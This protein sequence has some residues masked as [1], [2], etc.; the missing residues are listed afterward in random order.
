MSVKFSQ[1]FPARLFWKP[2]RDQPE[3]F[4]QQTSFMRSEAEGIVW[5]MGGNGAGTT[6][7]ALA[8]IARFVMTTPPPRPDCPI[9]IIANTLEQACNAC[10]KEKLFGHGHIMACDVDWPRIAWYK[11]NQNWPFSVPLKSWG[12]PG[13]NWKL[14]FKSYEQGREVMQAES[15]GGFV[16]VE[17]FPW[18]ILEEV[19]RG[20][21]EYSFRGNKI[22]EFTPVDPAMSCEIEDMVTEDRLPPG[23]EIY[24]AN[25]RCALEA[26][27]VSQSWFDQFFGMVSPEM[28]ETRLTGAFA[29]YEGAIYQSLNPSIH[30]IGDDEVTHPPNSHYRR[31]ID[32]GGGPDNAFVC[33]WGYRNG[34]GQWVIYDEYYSTDQTMTTVDHLCAV[35]DR[36]H[37]PESNPHYGTTY[38]DP[39]S[40]SDLRI[41]SKLNSYAPGRNNIWI[42]PAANNVHEGIEH[43]RWLLKPDLLVG[44][45]G[46]A[47]K[48]PRLFIH[49]A[50][51]PNLARQ[52][53]TYRWMRGNEMGINPRDARKEPLKKDDHA[54]DALRY[55]LFSEA[56]ITGAVPEAKGRAVD[57]KRHGVHL[58][59]RSDLQRLQEMLTNGREGKGS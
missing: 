16:F 53:R 37:W 2:R 14:V 43:V 24:R 46:D 34:K 54:V 27:H 7:C 29:S 12:K 10:W 13:N 40:P 42:T 19:L 57:S 5:L 35:D 51:C 20:C 58:H 22:C 36:E 52:M 44:H 4:D 48:E 6:E 9:W 23:W 15:I 56:R 1:D 17:Q 3:K 21:R 41:A 39:S 50:A 26:G 33:L 59:G 11:P 25:T 55:M 18:G 49:K 30:Y 31:A 47:K 45:N 8:K 38:A 28:L 32:W